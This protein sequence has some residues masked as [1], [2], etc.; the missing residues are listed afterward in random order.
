MKNKL[1]FALLFFALTSHVLAERNSPPGWFPLSLLDDMPTWSEV[2]ETCDRIHLY[3]SLMKTNPSAAESL[4]V[5]YFIVA[6]H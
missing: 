1:V 2:R 6:T 5:S 4:L 3:P